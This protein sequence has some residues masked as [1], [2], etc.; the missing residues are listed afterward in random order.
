M[1]R[2]SKSIWVETD[3]NNITFSLLDLDHP[4]IEDA[5]I[6]EIDAGVD[7]Y[8]DRRWGVT[9]AFCGYL[10]SHP[11]KLKDKTVIVIGAGVG[12][13]T[14]V[15]G[16]LCKKLYINDMAPVALKLCSKQLKKN[17]IKDYDVLPG[18]YVDLQVPDVD[19]VVGCF[20]VYNPDTLKSMKQFIE[21]CNVPVMLMDE[22][23]KYFEELVNRTGKEIRTLF[24][25]GIFQCVM[26]E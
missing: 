4:E 21:V 12:M 6:S 17:D 14:L 3:I 23:S 25:E 10:F 5:V 15:I 7:V 26:F 18:S 20:L 8:Y 9:E 2:L 11:E 16:R 13:E 19:L 22:S 1:S 24:S